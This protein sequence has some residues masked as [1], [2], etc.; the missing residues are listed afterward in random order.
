MVFWCGFL[1]CLV[2]CLRDFFVVVSFSILFFIS[3]KPDKLGILSE[4][5]ISDTPTMVCVCYCC[6]LLSA[7]SFY[8]V[9]CYLYLL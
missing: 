5:I 1:S 6:L 3:M 7:V 2:F 4:Q 9:C 8:V